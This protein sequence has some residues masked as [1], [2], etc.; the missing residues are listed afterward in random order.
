MFQPKDYVNYRLTGAVATDHTSNLGLVNIATRVPDEE[1]LAL[2][3]VSPA[4]LPIAFEPFEPIGTVSAAAAQ[5]TGLEVGTPVVAGWIDAF[6][7]ILGSGIRG[8]LEAFDIAGTS[9][10]VGLAATI[11]DYENLHPGILALPLYGNLAAIY[12]L[13]NNGADA[14]TWF[15]EGFGYGDEGAQME[16]LDQDIALAPAGS[17][18]LVF[19]PY[20]SGER[21]PV[22]D[23]KATGLLMG[24]RR[25]QM[26]AHFARAVVEGIGLSTR[27]ILELCAAA[28]RG[29]PAVVRVSGGGARSTQINQIKSDILG[30][31]VAEMAVLETAALGAAMLAAIGCGE[32]QNYE[33]AA[34]EMAREARRFEPRWQ[35]HDVYEEAYAKYLALYPALTSIR[36]AVGAAKGNRAGG[37]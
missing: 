5:E 37:E 22:W 2:L 10:I 7:N 20:L 29:N 3:G 1:F 4:L 8:P 18:G 17:D 27:Q 6:A 15:A 28:A 30:A 26:R 14:V 12:G 9:E 24:C 33:T 23:E 36:R 16:N 32:K 34:A 31:P 13:T 11:V 21:S 25:S 19:L 35:Y